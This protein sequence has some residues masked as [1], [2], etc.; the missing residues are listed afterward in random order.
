MTVDDTTLRAIQAINKASAFNQEQG[1]E[2]SALSSGR[3]TIKMEAKVASLNHAQ[4]LHAGIAAAMLDTAAGFAAATVAGPVVTVG[5]SVAY[6]AAS[7]GPCFEARA[8]VI[9]AGRTQVFVDVKLFAVG[10]TK[11]FIA[12]ATVILTRIQPA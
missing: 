7:N 9:R 10:D 3:A 11:K 1:F 12:T 5:L 6:V 4:T 2:V 8:D